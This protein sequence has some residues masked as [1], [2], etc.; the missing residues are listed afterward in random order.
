MYIKNFLDAVMRKS[1]YCIFKLFHALFYLTISI[2]NFHKKK[3]KK[4]ATRIATQEIRSKN[5]RF[6]IVVVNKGDKNI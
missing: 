1:I 3:K 4:R 2:H 6:D 5:V